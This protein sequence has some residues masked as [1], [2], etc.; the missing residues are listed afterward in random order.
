M[1]FF[2]ELEEKKN[3]K[4]ICENKIAELEN[5]VKNYDYYKIDDNVNDELINKINNEI[6]KLNKEKYN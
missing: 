6:S 3:V 1:K 4:E 5:L 2:K